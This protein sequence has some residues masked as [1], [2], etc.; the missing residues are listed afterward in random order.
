MVSDAVWDLPECRS[1][2]SEDDLAMK[3]ITCSHCEQPLLRSYR[4]CPRCE[5]PNRSSHGMVMVSV[6]MGIVGLLVIVSG[7]A[8][9]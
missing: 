3:L 2:N 8:L 1:P 5:M 7:L 6:T 4:V 9:Y